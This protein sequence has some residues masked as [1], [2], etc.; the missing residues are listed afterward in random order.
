MDVEDFPDIKSGYKI[1]FSFR[2]N[3][4]F[5]NRCLVKELHYAEDNALAIKGTEIVWTEEGV[6]F[7][8]A[9]LSALYPHSV[10]PLNICSYVVSHEII[11]CAYAAY[12]TLMIVDVGDAAYTCK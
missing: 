10:P 8:R 9:G 2:E 7:D 4:F 3:P 11:S 1:T 6:S 12:L 5:T